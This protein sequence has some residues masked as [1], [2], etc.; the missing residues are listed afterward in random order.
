MDMRRFSLDFGVGG[1]RD[2][3]M[4]AVEEN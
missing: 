3:E 1:G 4:K 2:D